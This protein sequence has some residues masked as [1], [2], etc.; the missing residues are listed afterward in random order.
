MSGLFNVKIFLDILILT[1]K[2]GAYL[3]GTTYDDHFKIFEEGTPKN[4]AA[5]SVTDEKAF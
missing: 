1:C 3:C 2:D 4:L 5:V